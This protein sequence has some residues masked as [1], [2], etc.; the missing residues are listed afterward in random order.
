MKGKKADDSEK[1]L[2]DFFKKGNSLEKRWKSFHGYREG[3]A[4]DE[5]AKFCQDN[6]NLV[7]ILLQDAVAEFSS[8]ASKNKRDAAYMDLIIVLLQTIVKYLSD[9]IG[10]QWQTKALLGII[11]NLLY[12][13]NKLELRLRGLDI[14]ISFVTSVKMRE[15]DWTTQKD[16]VA[17]LGQSFLFQPYVLS[18]STVKFAFHPLEAPN[19]VAVWLPGGGALS[20]EDAEQLFKRAFESIS[21]LNGVDFAVW[22]RMLSVNVFAVAFPKVCQQMGLL[23]A[24]QNTGFSECPPKLL[25]VLLT[26]LE[27]MLKD[28]RKVTQIWADP[29]NAQLLLEMYSQGMNVGSSDADIS[30]L[31]M[32]L[33]LPVFFPP[34][35][36]P[37]LPEIASRISAFRV[38]ALKRL[39][40]AF[41]KATDAGTL[42]QHAK[43]CQEV[44][45]VIGVCSAT[46]SCPLDKQAQDLILAVPLTAIANV[47]SNTAL[48]DLILRDLVVQTL[49][50]WIVMQPDTSWKPVETVM[51]LAMQQSVVAIEG[52]LD[53]FFQVTLI[54]QRYYYPSRSVKERFALLRVL[55]FSF[56]C[57]FFS[58]SQ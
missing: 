19:D 11:C 33:F 28:P 45:R 5:L 52:V 21:K 8:L 10:R 4:P 22:F 31:V 13:Q 34:S 44:L 48:A 6:F 41:S 55:S 9:L 20:I 43:L 30:H 1:L 2:K 24:D 49:R 42:V 39:A 23:P 51:Q 46:T 16:V 56:I 58:R 25:R 26:G 35:N 18:G 17:T 15:E 12:R 14:Y 37:L 38:Y 3:A 54:L 40:L 32:N 53:V 36:V 27:Q 57:S 47:L 50:R 29:Q 7:F